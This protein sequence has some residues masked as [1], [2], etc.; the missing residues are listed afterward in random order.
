[1][2]NVNAAQSGQTANGNS[3]SNLPTVPVANG[4]T[5]SSNMFMTLLV[6]QIKNQNPLEPTDA[7]QF[8]NQLTQMSQM[9][10]T[11]QQTAMAKNN[12]VLLE[13][14][15]TLELGRQVGSEVMVETSSVALDK[16]ALATRITLANNATNVTLVL[17]GSDGQT[18]P[19]A[20]GQH[21]A[22]AFETRIDPVALGLPAGRYDIAVTTENNQKPAVE[23]AGVVESVRV[24]LSGGSPLVKVSGVGEVGFA[25][26]SQ[27]GRARSGNAATVS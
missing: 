24:P 18:H 21:A 27:I 1:M 4:T 13:N 5:D 17:T 10:A 19:V 12:A 9:K 14:L 23:V 2:S 22:G 16:T 8:V 6:A 7:S 11:E 15:Q 26:I 3:G 25:N 20:L